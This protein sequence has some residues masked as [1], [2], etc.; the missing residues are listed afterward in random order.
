VG[1]VI[2][3]GLIPFGE[4]NHGPCTFPWLFNVDSP[5]QSNSEDEDLDDM[6]AIKWRQSSPT[7]WAGKNLDGYSLQ[8]WEGKGTWQWSLR[9]PIPDSYVIKRGEADS[10][11]AAKAA[12]EAAYHWLFSEAPLIRP[13]DDKRR[14][15]ANRQAKDGRAIPPAPG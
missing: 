3:I 4:C 2:D 12:V 11:D 8:V 14:R 13:Q 6:L 5:M 10:V 7:R 15:G 1:D 9:A